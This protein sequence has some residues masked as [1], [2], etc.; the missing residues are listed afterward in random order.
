MDGLEVGM[1]TIIPVDIQ[2][3][4]KSSYVDYAMSVIIGRALPDVRDGLKPVHRRVLYT[5]YETKNFHNQPYKKSARIV[6]DVMGKYHPH[7]DAAIYDTLVRMAQDFS[8]RYPLVDGQGNFG[9]IDG[10]SPAAMR[11]T[12]VR[13]AKLAEELLRDIEKDTVDMVPNYDGS[14]REPTVLPAGFPNLLVN[15]S[16]GIAVGMATN[17]PPHNLTEV[18]NAI[19]ALIENP[20]LSVIDLMKYIP[21]PDFPTGAYITGRKGIVDAY[22]KGRGIIRLKA[23]THIE[24]PSKGK[25]RIVVTEIPYQVNKAKLVERIAELVKKGEVT[26]VADLRDESDKSGMR[27]VI[28]VKRD[29][30]PRLVLNQLLGPTQLTA[31]FG[32]IMLAIVKGRPKVLNLKEMLVEFIEHRKDVVTRRTAYDLQKALARE[33]ILEGFKIALDYI[34]LIIQII[35]SSKTP[36]EARERLMERF[37]LSHVQA[38][39]ILDMKLQRLTGMER[40]KILEELAAIK[41]KI[42]E[43]RE[44]LASKQKLMGVI[45]D[46]LARIRD[47]Y[48]DERR[49]EITDDIVELTA[50]DLIPDDQVVITVTAAGYIKRTPI[51][52]YRSQKRGGK[53]KSGMTTRKEDIV[54][55]LFTATNLTPVLFFTNRGRVFLRKAYQIPQAQRQ[56]KGRSIVNLLPLNRGETVNT[57]L[58]IR[59]SGPDKSLVMATRN[60]II[61]RTSLD[62]FQNIRNNG[63]IAI[64]LLDNDDLVSVKI[65]NNDQ[66]VL[67]VTKQGQ[68]I[69]FP[70]SDVRSV[71]RSA[72]GVRG[73][74]LSKNDHV[75][76]MEILKEG[77]YVLTVTQRGFGKKSPE[78]EY[79][80]QHRG[81]S[82]VKAMKV[83]SKTGPVIGTISVK[84]GDEIMLST[85]TGTI[86]RLS[87]ND[88]RSTGRVTQ[89]VKLINIDEDQLVTSVERMIPDDT[90]DNDNSL[91]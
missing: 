32:V 16:S 12:E 41:Q 86:I 46:E 26:G 48:G 34:D 89:G 87:V 88:I 67:L 71:G 20:G 58:P 36:P 3:Q 28:E 74:K 85:N 17:I 5:M 8:M 78:S 45:K 73:I 37:G 7:G 25:P 72:V 44:I 50:E 2:D 4:M 43:L 11:Y 77:E 9:S 90:E 14:L 6:G 29:A 79:R 82:G 23:K 83:T 21:G 18:I 30:E 57:I 59:D 76:G 31:S 54:V 1:E 35:R 69:R 15:G 40:E 13:M 10:D 38:Q 51:S 52:Q 53:G 55:D 62:A 33:H 27:V 19:I 91:L 63:I 24:E 22:K 75:V 66:H 61:K 84:D 60:G 47:E 70:L 42:A 64:K 56:G 39:A 80:V 49:T 68:S 65:A 81:G